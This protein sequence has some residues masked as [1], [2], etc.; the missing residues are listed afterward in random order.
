MLEHSK[1]L[2]FICLQQQSYIMYTGIV[3][4]YIQLSPI[5]GLLLGFQSKLGLQSCSTPSDLSNDTPL[6][7]ITQSLIF[8]PRSN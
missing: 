2:C 1:L 7:Y 5:I 6:G 8:W 3:C 4:N